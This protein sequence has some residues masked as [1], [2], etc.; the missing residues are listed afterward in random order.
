MNFNVDSSTFALAVI[1]AALIGFLFLVLL[2]QKI[3][4]FKNELDYIN[5]EIRRTYGSEREAW[6]ARKRRLWLSLFPFF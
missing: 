4:R 6:K 2:V 3:T 1:L 5:E